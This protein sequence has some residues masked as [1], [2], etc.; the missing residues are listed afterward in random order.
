MAPMVTVVRPDPVG[1]P[2]AETQ[3]PTAPSDADGNER[4]AAAAWP[5]SAEPSAAERNTASQAHIA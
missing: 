3:A 2:A 4:G 1:E 5:A